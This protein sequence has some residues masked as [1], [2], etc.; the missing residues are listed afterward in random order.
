MTK[1]KPDIL[2]PFISFLLRYLVCLTACPLKQWPAPPP[3][4]SIM[5]F[6]LNYNIQGLTVMKQINGIL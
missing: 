5:D 1:V 4:V 6:D 2:I 3:S